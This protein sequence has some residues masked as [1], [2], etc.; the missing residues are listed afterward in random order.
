MPW[1]LNPLT[2]QKWDRF[3]RQRRGWVSLWILIVLMGLSALGELLVNSRALVVRYHGRLYF[4]TY[5][6]FHPGTDF[7]DPYSYEVDYRKLKE[8]LNGSP[9][10]WVVLPAVPYNEYESSFAPGS[11]PPTAPSW[12]D[13]HL[14]GTDTTGRDVLARLFYGFRTAMI[15]SVLYLALVYLIG[16]SLGCA[17]GYF[18]GTF[19]L[20]GQ[21]LVE[22]WANLPF[23][24]IVIIVAS[25]VTPNVYSLL[26]I[27]ALFSW[28]G[29]TYYL[30]T[31]TYREKAR[32]YVA[33]AEVLGAGSARIVFR[34]ILPNAVSTVVSFVPLTISDAITALT[35]LDFL[36][37]GLPAPTPSLGELLKEGTANLNAPWI[38]TSTFAALVLILTLVTFIGEAVREAFDPK[39]FSIYE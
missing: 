30:R 4:P 10:E 16:I 5:G 17:M 35:A 23:L 22:I 26:V 3:R 34:H 20:V 14:L 31:A 9:G 13:R 27:V 37:F 7:G 19:D 32:D 18:G 12:H 36:G 24:Y 38:V 15:F 29:M 39:K 21:R 8:R 6:R 11:Y 25:I 33:A 2:R 1:R 28:T